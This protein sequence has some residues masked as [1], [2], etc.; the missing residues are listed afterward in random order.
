MKRQS[1][2]GEGDEAKR[3]KAMEDVEMDCPVIRPED[4][5]DWADMDESEMYE[6]AMGGEP[7]S[8]FLSLSASSVFEHVS[9]HL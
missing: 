1:G 2:G 3:R 9:R 8:A 5:E 6:V 4:E 7:V